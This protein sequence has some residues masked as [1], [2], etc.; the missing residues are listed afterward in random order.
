[1]EVKMSGQFGASVD[2]LYLE[3]PFELKW[4]VG[5]RTASLIAQLAKRFKARIMIT[6]ADAT[7]SAKEIKPIMRLGLVA[8]SRIKIRINGPDAA[9]AMRTFSKV[10]TCGHRQ[11]RCL[12]EDCPS[13]PIFL[14]WGQRYLGYGCSKQ[15]VWGVTGETGALLQIDL[16]SQETPCVAL[17]VN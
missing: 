17:S 9:A 6:R 11:D 3:L 16:N 13:T 14:G 15:H 12:Y 4:R 8:G 2:G 7:I 10:F 5:A 1:M